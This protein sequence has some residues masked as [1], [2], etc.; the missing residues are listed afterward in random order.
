MAVLDHTHSV[1]LT[2]PRCPF[3]SPITR[4]LLTSSTQRPVQSERKSPPS[5]DSIELAAASLFTRVR[6]IITRRDGTDERS[7][8]RLSNI[9]D[10]D[11]QDDSPAGSVTPYYA[12]EGESGGDSGSNRAS[13]STSATLSRMGESRMGNSWL[14]YTTNEA[15]I[16]P[17]SSSPD[18]AIR[19]RS[20]AERSIA[21][22]T[23]TDPDPTLFRRPYFLHSSTDQIHK[24]LPKRISNR[25]LGKVTPSPAASKVG[26]IGR[27]SDDSSSDEE[28]ERTDVTVGGIDP[29][30]VR[31]KILNRPPSTPIPLADPIFSVVYDSSSSSR[32]RPDL[33]PRPLNPD[34]PARWPADTPINSLASPKPLI[35]VIPPT[36]AYF[37][38]SSEKETSA[39]AKKRSDK[40]FFDD[41]I[42]EI[43][44][45]VVAHTGASTPEGDDTMT[46]NKGTMTE[47][48]YDEYLRDDF[49]ESSYKYTVQGAKMP[50]VQTPYFDKGR[51]TESESNQTA[52]G[53]R[54][55]MTKDAFSALSSYDDSDPPQ[56]RQ[57]HTMRDEYLRSNA[58]L[59]RTTST[60]PHSQSL[61]SSMEYTIQK[62]E[63]PE[64][65]REI[66]LQNAPA[67]TV[68]IPFNSFTGIITDLEDMLNQALALASRAV[69]DSNT[70]LEER[71]ASMKSARESATSSMRNTVHSHESPRPSLYRVVTAPEFAES[72]LKLGSLSLK[73]FSGGH[74]HTDEPPER[75][76]AEPASAD[77]VKAR[78]VFGP[79]SASQ[80]DQRVTSSSNRAPKD[81]A[82]NTTPRTEILAQKQEK[83]S[84]RVDGL[85]V[86]SSRERAGGSKSSRSLQ[87]SLG[88]RLTDEEA[89]FRM[90]MGR[91]GEIILVKIP[92]AL[93]HHE[94]FS[95]TK[96]VEVSRPRYQGGWQWG[97]WGKRFVAAVACA[98]VGLIGWIVGNYHA[99]ATA[100]Q[101]Y[102]Q[103]SPY[104]TSLGNSMFFLGL[105]IPTSMLWPLSL[106]HGRKPYLLVSIALLLPLQLPQALSLPPY[107][108][109]A[110]G[111][112]GSMQ[113][114]IVC[115]LFFRTLSGIIL[116]LA[117]MNTLSTLI[118]LFGPDT[119]ACCRG[120]VVFSSQVPMEGQN[121]FSSI[122][123]GESGVRIGIW[124]GIYIWLFASFQGIGFV[125]GKITIA[126]TTPAWGFWIITIIGGIL[127]IFIVLGPEVRPPWS[128]KKLPQRR[129]NRVPQ[130][131][132][133]REIVERGE[134][135]MVVFGSSPRWWWEEVWAGLIL[136]WTMMK[137]I[138]FF[139][140][141][142]YV[143]WVFGYLIMVVRVSQN[144][145]SRCR[146]GS[147]KLRRSGKKLTAG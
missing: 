102:L 138:G 139:V 88:S 14:R 50:R 117:F 59:S 144:T 71:D 96:N 28:A 49:A 114:Y 24:N 42:Q 57:F 47:L 106:L 135:K 108:N 12:D 141:S 92:G 53:L 90:E 129:A 132:I 34:S 103:I 54:D 22:S 119:G 112:G 36:P 21:G 120:G 124:L 131:R 77:A 76:E 7:S 68:P 87:K 133:A 82:H 35:G 25:A 101:K 74:T 56:D 97:L 75:T 126:K 109:A 64:Y 4:Q 2:F 13:L 99:E 70:A 123:G 44:S 80:D 39:R 137:Q 136:S 89:K 37:T 40:V 107:T 1:P 113:P 18:S 27:R 134:I 78:K 52:E 9:D 79:L 73:D 41:E 84:L 93:G 65:S 10:D 130:A 125:F 32:T 81:T 104:V 17:Y 11:P 23:V 46:A 105:A 118:D 121:Q 116:G 91:N 98:V 29:E 62:K 122:P 43:T 31:M 142:L 67:T 72:A 30:H 147:V 61:D 26:T 8:S 38:S 58:A 143:G 20:G 15:L 85:R 63:N 83:Q 127:L 100:I 48:D 66:P 128:K 3:L 86:D 5:P 55:S 33:F 146:W 16:F 145:L 69:E 111:N 45:T 51:A 140:I 6:A 110:H 115:L 94:S 95:R 19:L 60:R